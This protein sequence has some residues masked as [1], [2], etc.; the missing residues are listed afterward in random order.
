MWKLKFKNQFT[1]LWTGVCDTIPSLK[2]FSYFKTP[3]VQSTVKD[4]F[5]INS[6]ACTA[7]TA[8]EFGVFPALKILVEGE[9]TVAYRFFVNLHYATWTLPFYY[10]ICGALNVIYW[11]K[12]SQELPGGLKLA[13][14][15]PNDSDNSFHGVIKSTLYAPSILINNAFFR[16]LLLPG[17]LAQG[18]LLSIIPWPWLRYS[19]QII[20]DS[21]MNAFYAFEYDWNKSGLTLE[22]QI[23][24]FEKHWTY[25]LGFGLPFTAI[26]QLIPTLYAT[27]TFAIV[28]P[29]FVSLSTQSTIFN[30]Q[31]TQPYRL[32]YFCLAKILPALTTCLCKRKLKNPP[33][34]KV[35]DDTTQ[36]QEIL[37]PVP[38]QMPYFPEPSVPPAET[39]KNP[40]LLHGIH[41]KESAQAFLPEDLDKIK[42]KTPKTAENIEPSTTPKRIAPL[43]AT[44]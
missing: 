27:H 17:L 5:V 22:Q 40:V 14:A 24:F 3:A 25:F 28:L 7:I 1:V 12:I 19:S 8:Y 15:Q 44:I 37:A 29:L 16:I 10:I 36:T 38:L 4:I 9:E 35:V 21:L 20:S 30:S 11:Q 31:T 39:F 32:P 18:Y 33:A 41:K 34:P 42:N 13:V 2:T 6:I 23:I 43:G 26:M